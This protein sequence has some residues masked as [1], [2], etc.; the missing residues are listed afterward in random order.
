MG[1]TF[2]GY[3]SQALYLEG[4][5]TIVVMDLFPRGCFPD[6]LAT[7]VSGPDELNED[8]CWIPT[9]K[10]IDRHNAELQVMIP[11]LNAE[12]D[13]ANVVIFSLHDVFM[14]A[15]RNPSKFGELSCLG[16]CHESL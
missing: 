3:G 13:G 11:N 1:G 14:S 5:R 6:K 8:G 15:I 7:Q 9:T 12:L 16:L 2:D 10:I 4:A